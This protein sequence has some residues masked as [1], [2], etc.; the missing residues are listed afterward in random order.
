MANLFWKQAGKK[1]VN[2][3]STSYAS[4]E[5]FEDA[6]FHS[7]EILEDIFL[8]K[9]QVRGGRKQGIPDIV[10]IDTDGNVCIIEIKNVTI[11]ASIIPQVLAYAFW[12]QENPDSIKN[13]WLE[14]P[15]QPED[16][17]VSWDNYDVRIVV[18]APTIERSTLE[19]VN[20]ITYPVDLIEV[21]RWIEG[22]SEFLL[23]NRLEPEA[24]RR[25]KPVRG[26]G[27]YDRA[28]YEEHY[29]KQSVAA[30]FAFVK[31]TQRLIKA[32]GWP[33]DTKFNKHYCGFRHGFFNAFG[34]NW[35]GSK[36]FAFFFKLPKAV[37]EKV[38]PTGLKMDR[39]EDGWKQA[40]YKIDPAKTKVAAF[41]P[42]F[43]KAVEH[44]KGKEK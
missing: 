8:I 4:E 16:V 20:S 11:D 21:K 19:L 24:H 31:D 39:Y 12:A 34:I 14:A 33:L 30:F 15:R 7:R 28:H 22:S 17:A 42:L 6:I 41:L 13:L 26:R 27:D 10:G 37:A 18:I 29:N 44:V 9:R 40:I 32:K 43:E 35:I 25:P 5:Q 23:V 38:Q 36:T 3:V 2:L 1:T